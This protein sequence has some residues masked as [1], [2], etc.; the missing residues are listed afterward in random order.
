[1]DDK[2]KVKIVGI[3]SAL[4]FAAIVVNFI[5]DSA[6]VPLI[7]KIAHSDSIKIYKTNFVDQSKEIYDILTEK[8]LKMKSNV[9]K[10]NK[11]STT[12]DSDS[13]TSI[14]WIYEHL[15]AKMFSLL[16]KY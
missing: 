11:F 8:S 15:K 12:S 10:S 2:I 4:F 9:I 16:H 6:D 13:I 7:N 14:N 3:A 1:M 5:P